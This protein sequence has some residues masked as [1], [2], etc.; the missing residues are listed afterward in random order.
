MIMLHTLK[1][2][3]K[4]WKKI[5]VQVGNM[6]MIS[7][8]YNFVLSNS[9][10]LIKY[11]KKDI[12]LVKISV[13]FAKNALLH[14][15]I[16]TFVGLTFKPNMH[17]NHF[18]KTS[19]VCCHLW[20]SNMTMITDPHFPGYTFYRKP[21]MADKYNLRAW[22]RPVSRSYE[23]NLQVG[24]NYYK[25]LTTYLDQKSTGYAVELPGALSYR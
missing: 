24:E 22:K 9:C 16:D 25:H 17:K 15:L 23:F 3:L 4:S 5:K 13:K 1:F 7:L 12:L 11:Y 19:S 21:K 10:I 18:P 14:L 8:R 2:L 20:L 6:F